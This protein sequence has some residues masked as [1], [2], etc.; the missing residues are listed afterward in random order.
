[1][2]E[3]VARHNALVKLAQ[4]AAE[5]GD[6]DVVLRAIEAVDAGTARDN[7]CAM[8]S[9]ALA[10]NHKTTAAMAV[11]NQISNE[12]ARNNT[13]SKIASGVGQ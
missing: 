5:A 8:C 1:M 9:E 4:D 2:N 7:T 6:G 10:R 3:D 12:A 13:L 11:A